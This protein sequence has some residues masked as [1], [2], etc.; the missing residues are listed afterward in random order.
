[1]EKPIDRT[2][3]LLDYLEGHLDAA[4]AR[5]L[6][7][8][9]VATPA[10]AT[11]LEELRSMQAMMKSNGRLLGPSDS[12]TQRVMNGL[13]SLPGVLSPRNG[14]LL[15][16]GI[17]VA[18]AITLF[19]LRAGTFNF[20]ENISLETLPLK[21]DWIKNPLP[22]ISFNVKLVVNLILICAMGVSFLILDR[23]ILRPLFINKHS[24]SR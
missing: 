5:R 1:M 21:K 8:E 19:L 10:L 11:Q 3:E 20:T 4:G 16:S 12:F 2:E 17:L 9:L 7:S 14:I 18:I 23:T 13:D 24:V 22:G 15:L 6:E